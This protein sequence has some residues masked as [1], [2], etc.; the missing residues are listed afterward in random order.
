MLITNCILLEECS[1]TILEGKAYSL[2]DIE[3]NDT[4]ECKEL[5]QDPMLQQLRL[6][7]AIESQAAQ[8]RD[9]SNDKF[10]DCDP[11]MREVDA[12]GLPAVLAYGEGDNRPNPDNDT[13]GNKLKDS[14]PDALNLMSAVLEL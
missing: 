3:P 6:I 10:K 8:D 1:L 11:E 2:G 13:G 5:E 7:A 4:L 9:S 12:I 14:K